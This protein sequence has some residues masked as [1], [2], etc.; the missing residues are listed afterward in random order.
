[1]KKT[2]IASVF[3]FSLIAM[4]QVAPDA[5]VLDHQA[6]QGF[7]GWLALLALP[8]LGLL[9]VVLNALPKNGLTEFMRKL[10]DLFSANI[11]HRK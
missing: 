10:I 6:P 7:G 2:I 5:P 8:L 3:L 9:Q 11:A 1:M 4:A